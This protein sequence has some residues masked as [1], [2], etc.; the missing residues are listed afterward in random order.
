MPDQADVVIVCALK[1]ERDAVI[2]CLKET[3]PHTK[4]LW[5]YDL[6]NVRTSAAQVVTVVVQTLPGMGSVQAGIATTQA[7]IDWKPYHV[8][9]VGIA[10]GR[11]GSDRELGD[12]VIAEQIVGY[13]LGKIRDGVTQRRYQVLRPAFDLMQAT[14]AVDDG[15]WVSRITVPRP[16]S[17]DQRPKVHKGVVAS[18]EKV[19]ADSH[20]MAELGVSWTQ[21]VAIEM[22]AY[23]TALATYQAA[24]PPGMIMVKGI[25][26]WADASKHDGWQEYAADA[27]AAFTV[28]L[29]TTSKI[30]RGSR[31]ALVQCS[32][33]H[34]DAE[35]IRYFRSCF[36]RP[37]FQIPFH[38]EFSKDDFSSA[39]GDTITALHTGALVDRVS[40]VVLRQGPSVSNLRDPHCIH[41]MEKVSS[42]LRRIQD[43]FQ[44]AIQ[45]G[46][47]RYFQYQGAYHRPE[48]SQADVHAFDILRIQL[49]ECF[50]EIC[51]RVGIP[52][53]TIVLARQKEDLVED[54]YPRSEPRPI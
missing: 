52:P 34:P 16:E 15:N 30:Y 23:G 32:P 20:L 19:V 9:L 29:L 35:A 21:L 31:P 47:F 4:G 46:R 53:V 50:N 5:T 25:C 27:A 10:G 51:R 7:I 40:R 43:E 42:T 13:E 17:P 8:I 6:A 37:A 18:G 41:E 11:Q 3:K 1:K 14:Y 54:L 28:E 45:S 38:L 2:R 49:L 36:H 26:D 33:V 22:E 12:L 24:N 44:R 39:I 48:G